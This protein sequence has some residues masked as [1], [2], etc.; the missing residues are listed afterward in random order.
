MCSS[1][2][3]VHILFEL[4]SQSY[5]HTS[6]FSDVLGPV[7]AS[8]KVT[9]LC[10]LRPLPPEASWPSRLLYFLWPTAAQSVTSVR[11][12][13][14]VR[15]PLKWHSLLYMASGTLETCSALVVVALLSLK[16]TLDTSKTQKWQPRRVLTN[17]GNAR[18]SPFEAP[19][20]SVHTA[21][22]VFNVQLF[23]A[24]RFYLIFRYRSQIE[25]KNNTKTLKTVES[26]WIAKTTI[27]GTWKII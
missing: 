8:S 7:V 27:P 22:F 20:L 23:L 16:E 9:A 6:P 2:R 21:F 18:R 25:G 12:S 15:L 11:C 3:P 24:I 13:L 17:S 10:F 19:I 14:W 1:A 5:T 26:T 4:W